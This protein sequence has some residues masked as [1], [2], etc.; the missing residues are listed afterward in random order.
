MFLERGYDNVTVA[1]I[2]D[3][4]NVSAN[5]VVPATSPSKKTWV[6]DESAEVREGRW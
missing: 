4:A 3:A 5:T 6:F 1:E 2:A